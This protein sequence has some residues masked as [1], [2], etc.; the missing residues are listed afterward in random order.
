MLRVI[1]ANALAVRVPAWPLNVVWSIDVNYWVHSIFM[2][3]NILGPISEP[4]GIKIID[5]R[6]F[7]TVL[8]FHGKLLQLFGRVFHLVKLLFVHYFVV[9]ETQTWIL[10]ELTV[11]MAALLPDVADLVASGVS[12]FFYRFIDKDI[13]TL[14]S[15]YGISL[16]QKRI[17]LV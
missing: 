5:L 6:C 7:L 17:F 3:R 11:L 12:C 16:E 15:L 14:S 2:L 9:H 8:K 1:R 13:F 10:A 4:I